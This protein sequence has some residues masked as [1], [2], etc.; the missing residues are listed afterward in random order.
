[1][2]GLEGVFSDRSKRLLAEMGN[3]RLKCDTDQNRKWDYS[4]VSGKKD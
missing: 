2:N 4:E 3:P 1:M